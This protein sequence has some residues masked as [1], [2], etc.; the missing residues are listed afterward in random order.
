MSDPW[1]EM[2]A[3]DA[4][5]IGQIASGYAGVLLYDLTFPDW[6]DGELVTPFRDRIPRE[7]G[8]CY[9]LRSGSMVHVKP[10]CRC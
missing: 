5:M 4:E 1:P 9:R 6:P 2:S 10:G 8:Q 3:E 7:G